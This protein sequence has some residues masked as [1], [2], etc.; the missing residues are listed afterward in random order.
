MI[1]RT[2]NRIVSVVV[3]VGI[4]AAIAAAVSVLGQGALRTAIGTDAERRAAHWLTTL[5]LNNGGDMRSFFADDGQPPLDTTGII[6]GVAVIA[7]DGAARAVGGTASTDIQDLR[8]LIARSPGTQLGEGAYVPGL[9]R[10]F[11]EDALNIW[12]IL[13]ISGPDRHRLA[14]RIPQARTAALLAD[15]LITQFLVWTGIAAITF[16]SFMAGF[17]FRRSRMRAESDEMRYLALHD[18]LT[19]L[20]NRKQF[21]QRLA[22]A[23]AGAKDKGHQCAV[24]LLDLDGFKSINDTLGHH[25]GDALLCQTA[26]RIGRSL[27]ETDLL[28]RLSGDEF[29]IVLPAVA[30]VAQITPTADRILALM[31]DPVTVD[32]HEI[33]VGCSIGI[34]VAPDNGDTPHE[35]MRNAD[36]ALYRAKSEGKRTWR[37]FNPKMAEDLKSRRMMEDGLRYALEKDL[38]ALLYQPQLDLETGEVAGYEALLRWSVPGRGLIPTSMFLSVAEETGLIVPMGEWVIRRAIA[39]SRQLGPEARVAINLSPAQLKRDGL[40][41]YIAEILADNHVRPEQIEIEVNESILGRNEVAAFERLE[42][43]RETGV[44]IVMDN[45]GVGT[46]SLGLLSRYPFDKIK[47]DRSFMNNINDDQKARAVV[48]AICSLGRSLGMSVAGEGVETGDHA[49]ILRAAGCQQGQGYYFGRPRSL[50]DILG[51]RI[52]EAEDEAGHPHYAVGRLREA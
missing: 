29:A 25:V 47:V 34:A 27:R 44:S 3:A 50:G 2:G 14:V 45:F 43:I 52:S 8:M 42:K 16:A 11:S 35:V 41:D 38:F 28:A 24:F 51:G 12:V 49:A 15:R 9:W 40:E 36:F 33:Q 37:F 7:P 48:A 21:E 19:G 20:A 31:A 5:L 39:D 13:P 18:Q 32:G 17:F 30:D 23:V 26:D 1:T 10:W 4:A 6:D 46:S 22:E